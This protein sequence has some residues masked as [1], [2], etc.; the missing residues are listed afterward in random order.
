ME[1]WKLSAIEGVRKTLAEYVIF[2]DNTRTEEFGAL[3]TADGAFVLPDGSTVVGPAAIVALLKGHQA[4]FAAN[5]AAAPPG[6]LR[7]QITTEN[8]DII[9]ERQAK[10]EAYFMT[11]SAERV[12]HWGRWIDDLEKEDDGRWRFKKRIVITD[13]Y[14]PDSWF[15][16]SFSK[17]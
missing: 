3:F 6:Y 4:Y 5:P 9:S 11:L 8:I 15:A 13:G 16:V 12:D 10:V 17:Q 2:T 7:H 14:Q 1:T